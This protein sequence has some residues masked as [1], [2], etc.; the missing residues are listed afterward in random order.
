MNYVIY[1]YTFP[2]GVHFGEH[3]LVTSGETFLAD[4]LFSALC[5]EAVK[6]GE[7][8][9]NQL[10]L[11]AKEGKIQISDAFPY[12]GDVY[13]LPKPVLYIEGNNEKGNSILKKKFKK[14]TYVPESALS[15]FVCGHFSFES[16]PDLGANIIHETRAQVNLRGEEEAVPYRVGICRFREGSGL[17]ILAGFADTGSERLFENLQ[18]AL[19]FTGI[20]GERSSGLG[21]F[22]VEMA[23]VPKQL[24]KRLQN[25]GRVHMTLSVALP[26]DEEM[27]EALQGAHF[28]VLKRSGFVA[29]DHYADTFR[30]KKDLYVFQAGSCFEKTFG[31]DVY[32]VSSGGAHPVYRYAKPMMLGVIE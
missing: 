7:D 8:T 15:D 9:L 21:R 11:L 18:C 26:K 13:L 17:Y 3:S 6:R 20:G 30:R 4:T 2:S 12:V 16:V 23:D 28:M 31:G 25:A 24:V 29:S 1:R 10:V 32:D 19:S 27:E 14:L 5:Q 22:S